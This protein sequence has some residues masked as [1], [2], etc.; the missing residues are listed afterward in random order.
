MEAPRSVSRFY[1]GDL[2]RILLLCLA[3]VSL[4]GCDIFT[5][6]QPLD[7]VWRL[8]TQNPDFPLATPQLLVM[9]QQDTIVTGQGTAGTGDQA[10]AVTITGTASLPHVGL[11]F[12]SARGVVPY[13]ATLQGA[14]QLVG[15]VFFDPTMGG[16][17]LT[18]VRR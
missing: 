15:Q 11:V 3:T 7:G 2:M 17:T 14:G 12:H 1:S 4:L 16:E 18:Y 5:P 9:T 10:V 8:E 13:A 6:N